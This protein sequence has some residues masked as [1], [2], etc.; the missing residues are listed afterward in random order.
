MNS[1]WCPVGRATVPTD[2]ASGG[3]HLAVMFQP[4]KTGM[5]GGGTF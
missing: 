3:G 1:D 2:S 4:L 5:V